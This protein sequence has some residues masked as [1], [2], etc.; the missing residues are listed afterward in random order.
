MYIG[1]KINRWTVIG[2][3]EMICGR[4]Y[5]PCKCDC[6][7][8]KSVY[9]YTIKSG[10]SK[11][12][13]CLAAENCAKIGRNNNKGSN[14]NHPLY[15][16]FMHIKR[17]CEN[18]NCHAYHRY[19]GRGIKCEFQNANEFILWA[20]SN[21]YSKGLH[22]DRIDN[23]GNYSP[24]NCRFVTAAENCNNTSRNV[25]IT[26]SGETKTLSQWCKFLGLNYSTVNSRRRRLGS[27]KA[28]LG[29]E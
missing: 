19:G 23:D 7:T 20:E 5:L 13:G 2:D 1:Q 18:S 10:K 9:H 16:I 25:F 15:N 21:G 26:H 28:A 24:D 6:G 4:K 3:A 14:W 12:C 27:H 22:V 29:F 8:V 11:S 17:R